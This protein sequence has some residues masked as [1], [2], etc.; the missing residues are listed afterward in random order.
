MFGALHFDALGNGH[1]RGTMC[2]IAAGTLYILFDIE[3]YSQALSQVSIS[4]DESR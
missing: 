4:V 3:V 1:I 2:R